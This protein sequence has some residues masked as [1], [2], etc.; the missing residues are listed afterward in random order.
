MLT[1]SC[2]ILAGGKSKRMGVNKAFLKVGDLPIIERVIDKA[3]LVG[4]E[5]ILVTN[6]PDEYAHLGYPTVQDIFPGKG[7]LGGIYSGLREARH[8]YVLVVACDMPFLNASLLRYMI[9]LSR[10]YDIVVPRTDQGVEPLH[11]LYSKACLPTMEQLLQQNNLKI[12]SFY[13]LFRV[14]YVEQEEVELLDP[15]HLSFFNVNTP[16]ALKWAREVAVETN[17][18]RK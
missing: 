10:G 11:A 1:V 7:S 3:S 15:Q 5:V 9:L 8:P 12:I 14:R 4:E 17:S 16:D 2:V 13:S 6:S 18:S